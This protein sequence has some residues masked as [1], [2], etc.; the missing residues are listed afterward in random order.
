MKNIQQEKGLSTLLVVVI[1]GAALL[2]MAKNISLSGVDE[3][4]MAYTHDKSYE[5]LALAEG[6]AEDTLRHILI[7]S[8]YEA[9][10]NELVVSN[11]TCLINVSKTG[12][13]YTISILAEI[14]EYNRALSVQVQKIDDE[15]TV[16]DWN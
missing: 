7:N 3:A 14:N 6:C 2:I 11:G 12:N 9:V 16:I 13:E 15:L 4:A 10:D 1:I 8:D 5:V